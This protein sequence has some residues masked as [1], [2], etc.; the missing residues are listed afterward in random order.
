VATQLG[1]YNSALSL[2]GDRGLHPSLGLTEDRPA[3]Y[4]LDD[5]YVGPPTLIDR[6]LEM[7]M[8][9]FAKRTVSIAHSG[10]PGLGFQ[11]AF[12]KPSDFIRII[13]IWTEETR[14]MP[15]RRY[16][17]EGAVISANITPI[18]VSYVSNGA[19]YGGGLANWPASFTEYASAALARLACPRIKAG[20]LADLE[21]EEAKR[22]ADAR[23]HSAMEGP[24]IDQPLGNWARARMGGSWR[25][26]KSTG[27]STS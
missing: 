23:S 26:R 2:L 19:S 12:P 21:K 8:W 7:G 10:T 1:L 15:L 5:A 13:G 24:V 3:R 16:D 18:I 14:S 27:W 17:S 20:A 11:Y 4:A 22:L 25:D 9:R 6:C